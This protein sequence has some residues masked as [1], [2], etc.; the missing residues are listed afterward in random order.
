MFL[1]KYFKIIKEIIKYSF[2]FLNEK[3]LDHIETLFLFIIS[4]LFASILFL[5]LFSLNN[6]NKLKRFGKLLF[7]SF[8][9]ITY[10]CYFFYKKIILEVIPLT[11]FLIGKRY[12]K[13]Q[14][15][16]YIENQFKTEAIYLAN[17]SLSHSNL[18]VII[19]NLKKENY[20][21]K[22][23]LDNQEFGNEDI[24][25]DGARYGF[26]LGEKRIQKKPYTID[27]EPILR[28]VAPED[29]NRFWQSN[30]GHITK[31][32]IVEEINKVKSN[33]SLTEGQR[34][35]LKDIAKG[36][37]KN[38]GLNVAFLEDRGYVKL[39]WDDE[40]RNKFHYEL[41]NFGKKYLKGL[42]K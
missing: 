19:D 11:C 6:K 5:L 17:K 26:A 8:Y 38:F 12:Y 21:L 35:A 10:F 22:K 37:R 2:S 20:K 36:S 24:Y 39:I 32:Y 18:S 4:F 31:K 25:W 7:Y 29:W 28:E 27:Y 41:T 40:K 16:E 33:S 3:H 15:N 34:F 23:I 30:E 1:S 42:N 13:N 9:P 14:I